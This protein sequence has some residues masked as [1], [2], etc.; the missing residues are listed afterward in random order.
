VIG[1][2]SRHWQAY[3][4]FRPWAN[5][6]MGET[7]TLPLRYRELLILRT[8]WLCASE[9]EWGQHVV[10]ARRGGVD[11]ESIQRVRQGADAPGWTPVERALLRAADEL[12]TAA[13]ILG[14]TWEELCRH[15]SEEQRMD[16]VFTVGMYTT[17]SMAL[18]SFDVQRDEGIA[19]F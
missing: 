7:Q 3:K 12:R 10:I 17:I 4:K 9:Y 6:V 8:G 16:V 2:L 14:P 15:L 5:H 18:N 19:G 11:E 1:T 13:R